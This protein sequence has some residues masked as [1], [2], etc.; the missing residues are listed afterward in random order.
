MKKFIIVSVFM[1]MCCMFSTLC[2]G[3]N[4]F[5]DGEVSVTSV[6]ISIKDESGVTIDNIV[7]YTE[8]FNT[9]ASPY[10]SFKIYFLVNNADI[11]LLASASN[12]MEIAT[13]L[14]FS[15]NSEDIPVASLI[16][17]GLVEK[18]KYSY[19]F[20]STNYCINFTPKLPETF[21]FTFAYAKGTAEELTA[22]K[23][24][25]TDYA[26]PENL[27][28]TFSSAQLSIIGTQDK[29]KDTA[30]LNYDSMPAKIQVLGSIDAYSNFL[31]PAYEYEYLWEILSFGISQNAK[32]LDLSKTDITKPGDINCSFKITIKEDGSQDRLL[33]KTLQLK[34]TTSQSPKLNTKINGSSEL[35]AGSIEVST[36]LTSS[37]MVAE[38]YVVVWYRKT[39]NSTSYIK[40]STGD[41]YTV[42][43]DNQAPN[44]Y[45]YG[46]YSYIAVATTS[47]SNA[48]YVS[49]PISITLIA[50]E[51]EE[52]AKY[53]IQ[54]ESAPNTKSDTEAF[55]LSL[56]SEDGSPVYL[57]E[58][59]I[60][61]V[62]VGSNTSESVIGTGLSTIFEPQL[63][64]TYLIDVKI[65]SSE[66]PQGR[67][68]LTE[69]KLQLIS[70]ANSTLKILMYVGIAVGVMALGL[71]I[72]IIITT[73]K[74]ELIW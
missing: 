66:Y 4:I 19:Q 62:V 18:D 40:I 35:K 72:S 59:N 12:Y 33:E 36:T 57:N 2:F 23:S 45:G 32:T 1:M 13:K 58:K 9:L 41:S 8:D 6:D 34:I 21:N 61:W 5:A 54:K 37:L 52:T 11:R 16:T 15:I 42:N 70:N 17:S 46:E 63:S 43:I 39:P 67:S 38:N 30:T 56:V 20:D 10:G 49:E 51:I 27:E 3:G 55:K 7:D 50:S 47:T 22:S 14:S 48:T 24:I 60:I 64:G 29:S 74:R 28:I 31:N 25:R 73:K 44:V 26:A 71:V 68:L 65:T 53:Y 69:G